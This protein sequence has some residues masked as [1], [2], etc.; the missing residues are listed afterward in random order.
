MPRLIG[1]DDDA[2]NFD[3]WNSESY[4]TLVQKA[5]TGDREAKERLEAFNSCEVPFIRI[6][7]IDDK[8]YILEIDEVL[9]YCSDY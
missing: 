4:Q 7:E 5:S 1:Y 2:A 8:E 6:L 9:A 3:W